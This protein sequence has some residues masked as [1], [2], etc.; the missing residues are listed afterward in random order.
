MS[1]LNPNPKHS[2]KA[3]C[4][5]LQEQRVLVSVEK[6][7]CHI[8]SAEAQMWMDTI[9]ISS[10]ATL[11]VHAAVV[12][13]LGTDRAAQLLDYHDYAP[14]VVVELYRPNE[15]KPFRVFRTRS[16]MWVEIDMDV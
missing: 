9:R 5:Q 3:A 8:H 4:Y 14:M 15:L 11:V 12:A 2:N 6:N 7:Q 1:F 16:P 10:N 13:W